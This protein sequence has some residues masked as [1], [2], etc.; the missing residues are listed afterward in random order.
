MDGHPSLSLL[1]D[2]TKSCFSFAFET[3]SIQGVREE[4]REDDSQRQLDRCFDIQVMNTSSQPT[5][6]A[7][8][9]YVG[10]AIRVERVFS[11]DASQD[12]L[13]EMLENWDDREPDFVPPDDE[14]LLDLVAGLENISDEMRPRFLEFLLGHRNVFASDPLAPPASQAPPHTIDLVEGAKPVHRS[15]YRSNPV[16]MIEMMK[17]VR[18]KEAAGLI[19]PSISPFSAPVLLVPKP[20]GSWRFTVDYRELNKVTVPDRFPLPRIDMM[21]DLMGGNTVFSTMDLASGFYQVEVAEKDRHKTAFAT[22]EGLFEW[23]R[24]PM[25]L[26]NSPATFQR[27]MNMVLSG[28]TWQNC[29]VYVDDVIVFSRSEEEHL[30][31]LED[32]FTRLETF[33]FSLK[34]KKCSFFQK[35]VEYLGHV[36]S[37]AGRRP[38]PSNLRAV[39][40]FPVPAGK[41]AITQ[42]QGFVGLCNYYHAYIPDYSKKVEPLVRLTKKGIAFVWTEEQQEAFEGLKTDLCSAPL[43]RHPDFKRRFYIQT[44]ACGYGLGA[45]LT[46]EFEDG[47]HP[48]LFLSRSLNDAERKW[49]ARELEALAVVWAVTTL[50]PYIEGQEFTVQTDHESLQWL[51]RTDTPGRLSRWALTL[52]EFL[53]HMAIEYRRGVDNGNADFLSRHPLAALAALPESLQ[54]D[55]LRAADSITNLRILYNT[56]HETLL[57]LDSVAVAAAPP[58][59]ADGNSFPTEDEEIESEDWPSL[60]TFEQASIPSTFEDVVREEYER[61]PTWSS[62]LAYLRD[63]T[64]T[65]LTPLETRQ[66]VYRAEHFEEKDGLLYLRGYARKNEFDPRVPLKRLVIPDRLVT[67]IISMSHDSVTGVHF[68]SSRVSAIVRAR[69]FWPNQDRDVREFIRT[70]ERCQKA[71]A[72][73]Q[74]SAGLLQPKAN[75]ER[76]GFLSVDLQGPY[77]TGANSQNYILTIKDIFL[78]LV[79]LVPLRGTDKGID[80]AHC[81][82]AIF[83]HWIQYFGIPR[84]ILTDQ[85]TQFEARLFQRFCERLGL[86]RCEQQPITLRRTHKL[87]VNM[88][89]T[90]LC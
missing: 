6:V 4:G 30:Q 55:Y 90:P 14:A 75:V 65:S 24:M 20:D 82:E 81:A 61:D 57:A 15:P 48:I 46:Q 42:V 39:R 43:L 13:T 60:E 47:F 10:Q 41:N 18:E 16:K 72:T 22:P 12:D 80:G 37:A 11:L 78:G 83:T 49:A 67:W 88:G 71:K 33:G 2:G 27:A 45:V 36:V 32:V 29:L 7:N 9:T 70:C 51:M 26:S 62:L 87:N 35:E 3:D 69:Y 89:S 59:E 66:M 74:L 76:P 53:P 84:V 8:G 19:Q 17:Q 63:P 77:P 54:E 40:D 31:H 85:G 79:V 73:R 68:G 64:S 1:A 25:G 38:K 5:V 23:L 44:D 21:L 34:M 52:Q 56:F 58:Q 86:I 28:L 50:R